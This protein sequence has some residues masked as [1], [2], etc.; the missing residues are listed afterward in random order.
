MLI[1]TALIACGLGCWSVYV[2]PYRDQDLVRKMLVGDIG[3]I[4]GTPRFLAPVVGRERFQRIV[5]F[6]AEPYSKASNLRQLG[7]LR[8][9]ERLYLDRTEA[10][11]ST[12]RQVGR[13]ANLQRLSLW[14]TRTSDVGLAHLARCTRLQALDLHETPVTNDGLVALEALSDLR[15]L[16]LGGPIH[17]P[18]LR[19]VAKLPR[20][21]TLDLSQ[22]SVSSDD[23]AEL[24]GSPIHELALHWQLPPRAIPHLLKLPNLRTLRAEIIDANDADIEQLSGCRGLRRVGISGIGLSDEAARWLSQL[25][26][27][28]LLLRGNFTDVTLDQIAAT[29]SLTEVHLTGRFSYEGYERLAECRPDLAGTIVT[30]LVRKQRI[31]GAVASQP[32]LKSQRLTF[33]PLIYEPPADQGDASTMSWPATF[34]DL[35]TDEASTGNHKRVHLALH[36]N[37]LPEWSLAGLERLSNLVELQIPRI[38]RDDMARLETAKCLE[39]L[40]WYDDQLT[41]E[42]LDHV[43]LP[44]ML[45]RLHFVGSRVSASGLRRLSARY[46]GV[47]IGSSGSFAEWAPGPIVECYQIRQPTIARIAA[48][49]AVRT[50]RLHR[51]VGAVSLDPL[52]DLPDLKSLELRDLDDRDARWTLSKDLPQLTRLVVT[53]QFVR[54]GDMDLLSHCQKV[55]ELELEGTSVSDRGFAQIADLTQLR[56]LVLSPGASTS[57]ITDRALAALAA[58]PRLEILILEQTQFTG[59][60]LAE[61]VGLQH[62]K[63]IDLGFGRVGDAACEALSKMPALE[64]LHLHHTRITDAGLEW[65]A[66]CPH[67]TMLDVSGTTITD[68]GLRHLVR[69][70]HL[71]TLN[72]RHT[73]ITPA[74]LEQLRKDR[75]DLVVN[76]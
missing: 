69:C 2:K 35:V 57:W 73:R 54:D 7:H 55:K 56:Q 63:R 61:L 67:L 75:P 37:Q 30:P 12:A 29:K 70:D 60:G 47:Q 15:F 50:V 8:F 68:A 64:H 28:Y 18:A 46:P 44:S 33:H 27:E 9:L 19:A 62:L 59:D 13:L 16:K 39:K 17:G 21:E 20:L 26:L 71:R 6:R 32:R 40:T 53:G 58:C 10:D 31:P 24:A 49:P 43:R 48:E 34:H 36:G 22:T 51:L 76:P 1:L 25:E 66:K 65:L 4:P 5:Q 52:A 41:D 72:V 23:L 45:Q 38:G 14:R 74:G 11:D 3:T 42:D